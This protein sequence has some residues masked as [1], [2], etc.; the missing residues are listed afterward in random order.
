MHTDFM[1]ASSLAIH[2]VGPAT[3]ASRL[4]A[5]T[6]KHSL[7]AFDLVYTTHV[8]TRIAIRSIT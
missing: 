3:R 8:I 6:S 7:D 4:S 5:A 1:S 2:E